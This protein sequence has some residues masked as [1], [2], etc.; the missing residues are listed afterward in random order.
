MRKKKFGLKKEKR[1]LVSKK[2]KEIWSRKRNLVPLTFRALVVHPRGDV[3]EDGPLQFAVGGPALGL[4]LKPGAVRVLQAHAGRAGGGLVAPV[5]GDGRHGLVCD[6]DQ[7]RATGGL[8]GQLKVGH[9]RGILEQPNLFD[10]DALHFS[11]EAKIGRKS[12]R[13]KLRA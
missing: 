2:K 4:P 8:L 9:V 3:L 13:N 6:D 7:L 11:A 12:W 5:Q 10:D 1:N